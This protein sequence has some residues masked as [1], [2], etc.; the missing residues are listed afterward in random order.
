LNRFSE[1]AAFL[2]KLNA[3][4]AQVFQHAPVGL[5]LLD[6][7]LRYLTVNEILSTWPGIA[8]AEF[9]GRPLQG[10]VSDWHEAVASR[11]QNTLREG[12]PVLNIELTL[13][14]AIPLFAAVHFLARIYFH[15]SQKTTKTWRRAW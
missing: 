14:C 7:D 6:R 13:L 15:Y 2:Q 9:A 1:A 12:K 11:F 5:A 8:P 3:D 10:I 4:L